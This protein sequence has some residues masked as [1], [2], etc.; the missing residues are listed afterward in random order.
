[1]KIKKFIG[2]FAATACLSIAAYASLAQAP[3]KMPENKLVA[4]TAK[5]IQW[6]YEGETGP[7]KWANLDPSFSMCANGK[8]QSPIDIEL[9][10][11]K[12]DKSIGDIKINYQPTI[13]TI[14]NNGHTIQANDVSRKNSILIDGDEYTLLQMHFHTPS[15]HKIN[16]QHYAMEGHFIHENSEG[17]RAVLAVLIEA[18]NENRAL[19]EMWSKLPPKVTEADIPLNNAIDLANLLPDDKKVFRY[20]GSLTTPPCSEGIKWSVLEQNI[21]MSQEQIDAFSAI[22]PHNNRPIQPLNNRE[23]LKMP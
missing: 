17:K 18:G 12:L 9:E 21:E 15:E 22:F 5:P 1:M 10:D 6:S 11:V 13:F 20:S 2:L 3:Q 19:A 16:E 7:N 8:E 4:T 23:V 14:M